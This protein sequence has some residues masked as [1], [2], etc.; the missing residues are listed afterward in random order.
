M[1]YKHITLTEE[2]INSTM[3]K[4]LKVRVLKAYDIRGL[5][6]QDIIYEKIKS[7]FATIPEFVKRYK[8][9]ALVNND[10]YFSMVEKYLSEK[11]A[12]YFKEVFIPKY[13]YDLSDVFS[14]NKNG[15]YKSKSYGFYFAR[16]YKFIKHLKK[17]Y[18]MLFHFIEFEHRYSSDNYFHLYQGFLS[19][20]EIHYLSYTYEY[21]YLFTEHCN[22]MNK[23][24][25][26]MHRYIEAKFEKAYQDFQKNKA[27]YQLPIQVNKKGTWSDLESKVEFTYCL[28]NNYAV[29]LHVD[30]GDFE[31]EK[32]LYF[33]EGA[34][35][36]QYHLV[37]SNDTEKKVIPI[38]NFRGNWLIKELETH[39]GIEK[40]ACDFPKNI[41]IKDIFEVKEITKTLSTEFR[42]FE[43]CLLGNVYDYCL[44]TQ[45]LSIEYHANNYEECLVGLQRKIY[46]ES[47]KA[48]KKVAFSEIEELTKHLQPAKLEI[49][50]KNLPFKT[51]WHGYVNFFDCLF[52][53]AK[54]K[55]HTSKV[56]KDMV[57]EF[58]DYSTE[59][60]DLDLYSHANSTDYKN[61]L[62][63]YSYNGGWALNQKIVEYLM[64]FTEQ[65]L[66][67]ALFDN[68]N[69][70][71]KVQE[72]RNEIEFVSEKSFE[73]N[74]AIF[75]K[76]I[77]NNIELTLA[78]VHNKF[79]WCH[80]GVKGFCNDLDIDVNGKITISEM[81]AKLNHST[82]Q[83]YG[84]YL[85][86]IGIKL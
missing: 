51:D 66:L 65:N 63:Y 5:V 49:K 83:R 9:T 61:T 26:F 11:T 4:W 64:Y 43:R 44:A 84:S 86:R 60:G 13:T 82:Y 74:K 56:S 32:R 41:Q 70:C 79:G 47:Q 53:W 57:K 2:I 37:I 6:K 29:Y 40:K 50:T 33:N 10:L 27:L 7:Y 1:N 55:Y 22:K 35:K 19:D 45:D 20:I 31:Q 85:S 59:I 68:D 14:S 80:Q 72:Y 24:S 48:Y 67:D 18:A 58:F 76:N 15:F 17:K 75:L 73:E 71:S 77:T 16:N 30:Y 46:L 3:P 25:R 54:I 12:T 39:I 34:E 69:F 81:V 28:A 23:Q 62:F 21:S 78:Y 38:E 42:Y 8:N 36:K 52:Q